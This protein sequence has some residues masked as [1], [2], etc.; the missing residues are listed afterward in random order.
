M[1]LFDIFSRASDLLS[2]NK[3]KN[4][5]ARAVF[6]YWI[7]SGNVNN[8]PDDPD[9]YLK[10]GYSANTTVYSIIS[11]IDAMRKQAKLVLKDKAGN[12]V[13]NHELLKFRDR[14]NKSLTT[15]DAITQMLIYK[16]IIGEWFVY[17]MA[18]TVGAN[19]GKVAELH[20]LPANDVE[21]IEGTI[22]DPVRGYK[23]EGNYQIELPVESVYHGKLFN[24]NWSDERTLHGM[25]PLRA[26]ANTVSKLNQ[27]E[28]TE[29]KAFENQGPPYILFKESSTDPM[30]NRMSDPQRDEIV[31]KIKN[32]A[33]EN[34][35]SLPLVLKDKFGKLD[36]GQKLADMTIIES[37]NSGIIALC[38]VY[39]APPELFGYGQKTYNNMKEARKSMW[40]DCLMPNLL[41]ISDTLDACTIY[42]VPEYQGYYWDFDYSDIEELQEGMEIKVGWMKAAGWS[43]NEIRKVTGKEPIDN[44]L[45]DEPVIGMGDTFLSDY[46]EALDDPN[47]DDAKDFGDY[48]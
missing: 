23:I 38:A 13:E 42:D 11:R 6:E 4:P 18:P 43:Y 14:F 27:I 21:I 33:K 41:A 45:M 19:K 37:S 10:K 12:V 15:N 34:N 25:S 31:K 30:Q 3:D 39:G 17:K 1:A 44:P 7:H 26:A 5:L 16:L 8:I 47:N 20:L 22:F 24:P 36:L 32:A 9:E 40:T 2:R 48:K 29:T 35:R 28:I 46:G